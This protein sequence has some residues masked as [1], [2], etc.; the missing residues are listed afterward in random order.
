MIR[1]LI[2]DDQKTVRESLRSSLESVPD[3]KVLGAADDGKSAITQVGK[4]HPDLVL[5]D[6]EMP[7]LDGIATTRAILQ[8]YTGVR[9]IV[10]SMHDDDNYVAQAVR[11]GAMGY[12]IKNTP[13]Q[14]LVEAIKSVHRGYAQ[15]GPGLLHKVITVQ[16]ETL[17]KGSGQ[18]QAVTKFSDHRVLQPTLFPQANRSNFLANKK[19]VYWGIW[20]VGNLLIWSGSLLYL[21]F[22]PPSFVSSW[23]IALPASNSSTNVDIP[24]VGQAS[25]ESESPFNTD[26][27]DPRENYRFLVET[28]QVLEEAS[29]RLG[30][31]AKKFGKPKIEIPP[32]TN[33]IKFQVSGREPEIAQNK[34]IAV[35]ESLQQ[36]LRSLREDEN[37]NSSQE[38]ENTFKTTQIKLQK[39]RQKLAQFKIDSGLS[40]I[41]QNGNLTYNIE[42]LRKQ[43]AQT[44]AQEEKTASRFNELRASLGLSAQEATDALILQSD[45]KFKEYIASYGEVS[46]QLVNLNAKFSGN[47]PAVINKQ[48][49]QNNVEAEL[50][51]RAESLLGKPFNSNNLKTLNIST[52]NFSL[53]QKA[54]LFQELIS[55]QAEQRSLATQAQSLTTQIS[56]LEAKLAKMSQSG[57]EL[58]KLQREVQLAEAVFSSTATRLELAKSQ[59]SASYPPVAVIASPTLPKEPSSPSAALVLMGSLLSSGMLTTGLFSHWLNNQAKSKSNKSISTLSAANTSNSNGKAYYLPLPS[60]EISPGKSKK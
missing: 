54:N 29:A 21:K 19:R 44:V 4:L 13:T 47:H 38:L 25:S 52:D 34:A 58:E 36:S 6:M 39:A 15:I 33:L 40:S 26:F 56:E 16:A 42:D 1:I 9:V 11:A 28:E 30:I 23:A 24:G 46:S 2:V 59:T 27:S 12:L 8:Q 5:I 7:D 60:S 37:A 55:L 18:D 17:T 43:Q 49:E 50:Y 20:L 53:S 22:K 3:I 32:N 10:L 51:S 41:E 57:S 35:Q 48:A 45:P 31:P 14:D